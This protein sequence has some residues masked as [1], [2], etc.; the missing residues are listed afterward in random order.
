MTLVNE[1]L[2]SLGLTP[3][4]IADIELSEHTTLDHLSAEEASEFARAIA[5]Q[6]V[7]RWDT[8]IGTMLPGLARYHAAMLTR[9]ALTARGY[10][11]LTRVGASS[12]GDVAELAP[13]ELFK[14]RSIG[15]LSVIDIV[16]SSVQQSLRAYEVQDPHEHGELDLL[17]FLE[18]VEA[19]VESD[20]SQEPDGDRLDAILIELRGSGSWGVNIANAVTALRSVAAWGIRE[21]GAKRLSDIVELSADSD[22]LPTDLTLSWDAF[23]QV[24]LADVADASL[25]DVTLDDLADRLVAGM[26]ERQYIVYRRRVIDGMTLAKVGEELSVSRERIRQLQL[27]AERQMESLLRGHLFRPLHWRAAGLRTSLGLAAPLTHDATRTALNQALLGASPESVEVLHRLTLRLAGPYSERAGW[28]VLDNAETPDPTDIERLADEFGLI[29][30]ADSHDWLLAHGVRPEFHDAW[31]DDFGSFRRD[32]DHL[33]VWSGNVIEKSIAV[34]RA[35]GEP[36]SA[37]DLVALVSEGH[38]VRGVRARLFDDERLMR[39]NRTEWA[40]R[41]WGLEEYTGITDEIAQRIEE[42]GGDADVTEIVAEVVRQFGV[43]ES[44][45]RSYAAAPMFIVNEGRIRLR[46]SD[47][48][49]TVERSLENSPGAFRSSDSCV[50]LVLPVDSE[51]LRGS[52]RPLNGAVAAALGVSPGRPRVFRHETGTLRITW[53]MTSALGPSLG[54]VRVAASGVGA[55]LGDRLRLDFDLAQERVSTRMIPRDLDRYDDRE[56]IRLLTGISARPRRHRARAR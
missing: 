29:P 33:M 45:V 18:Q 27:K 44:S 38:N 26:D 13:A 23:G 36:T 39:V 48:P 43:K 41:E 35:L 55:R 14:I 1:V 2:E 34:L 7:K 56:R 10:N 3:D 42:A 6:L 12:W 30:L 52:G 31:L 21:R 53:P 51:I 54:S 11:A 19:E 32:G 15:W 16:S 28:L 50:S 17:S 8:P 24:E 46:A 47:E 9:E 22:L 4:H 37:E 25:L 49:V 5:T 20:E 40:L